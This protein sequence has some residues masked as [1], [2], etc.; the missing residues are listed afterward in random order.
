MVQ[1]YQSTAGEDMEAIASQTLSS[2]QKIYLRI[3]ADKAVYTMAYSTDNTKWITLKQVDGK[4]L[5]TKTAGGFVGSMFG[6]YATS[7]GK[8]SNANAYYDWFEYKGND[9]VYN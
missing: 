3:A 5:S 8:E 2:G 6:V 7:S 1:V 4:F 9:A